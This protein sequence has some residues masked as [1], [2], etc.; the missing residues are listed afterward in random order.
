MCFLSLSFS[1][2]LF[3][4]F[5]SIF[6]GPTHIQPVQTCLTCQSAELTQFLSKPKIA[7]PS[8]PNWWA[9]CADPWVSTRFYLS[10]PF[11]FFFR[12]FQ[13]D[14]LF[15][16]LVRSLLMKN[17]FIQTQEKKN[18]TIK[19]TALYYSPTLEDLRR[20]WQNKKIL[21]QTEENL[22]ATER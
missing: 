7:S 11:H 15:F 12:L 13:K 10:F 1:F 5:F 8:Q 9:K 14:S 22:T 3:L 4:F 21:Y 19:K 17:Y 16:N 6:N 2:L 18:K 20:G